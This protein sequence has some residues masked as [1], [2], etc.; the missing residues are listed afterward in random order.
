M[1]QFGVKIKNKED[2]LNNGAKSRKLSLGSN[3]GKILGTAGIN[4]DKKAFISNNSATNIVSP[5]TNV[6][7]SFIKSK[8][9]DEDLS[10]SSRKKVTSRKKKDD[11][12]FTNNSSES[13]INQLVFIFLNFVVIKR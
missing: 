10:E 7:N 5:I 8:K 13:L 2:L 11:D 3:D 4:F 6:N 12:K 9:S 1:S